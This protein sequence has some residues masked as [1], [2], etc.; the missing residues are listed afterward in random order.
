MENL[1]QNCPVS[2]SWQAIQANEE[3]PINAEYTLPDYCP[4]MAVVLK[5][6]AYPRIQNRQLSG[7]RLLVDGMAA[8]RVLY[9]DE[10]RQC[11]RSVEFTAPFSCNLQAS[12]GEMDS[13]PVCLELHTKYV[14]CRA[15]TPRRLEVRGVISVH[16]SADAV[17]S[18]QVAQPATDSELYTRCQSRTFTTPVSMAEKVIS[19]NEALE[20]PESLP[21]AEMLLGGDCKAVVTECKLLSGKAIVKG[22][23]Y[24]HQLYTD[25]L[26]AGT[27]HCLDFVLPF[28]QIL[29]VE[30]GAEG[31]PYDVNV[32][33][34]SDTERCSV[35]PD[36]G[37]TVLE[38]TAKILVQLQ[39]YR[40]QE[41]SL[42]LDAY[43]GKY[44]VTLKSNE[45]ELHTYLGCRMEQT[46]L[47]LKVTLPNGPL[48]EVLDVW[49]QTGSPATVC[50]GQRVAL[51][52]RLLVCMLLRDGDGQI[53]YFEHPE[54]YRLEYPCQGNTPAAQLTVTE[55]RYRVCD[56][57]LELQVTLCVTIKMRDCQKHTVITDVA[58][59]QEKPYPT[60]R[61]TMLM[62]YA[63]PGEDVWAIG[64]ACHTSPEWI[65]KENELPDFMIQEP[66]VLVVPIVT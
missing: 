24:V 60:Q 3:C 33:L 13:S 50:D 63:Q 2:L 53:E 51:T 20:F 56:G 43:H 45:L 9:L 7:D 5:C 25:N 31:M 37:N 47:P 19:V 65:Q 49:V 11:V 39:I 52:D 4:D 64:R 62:Y 21:G 42:L 61:A 35:G 18:K 26:T 10:E 36:G 1:L 66:R 30:K 14:N 23:I 40:T 44:P 54:E 41:V 15:V 6:L 28:S 48:Q 46:M 38:V 27:T 8:V 16:A 55:L 22:Q 57:C 32:L 58:L 12:G 29:D 17:C 59:C 34:L